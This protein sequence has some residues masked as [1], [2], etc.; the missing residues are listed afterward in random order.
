MAASRPLIKP[1]VRFSRIRL[2]RVGTP[3]IAAPVTRQRK[4]RGAESLRAEAPLTPDHGINELA[5]A[6]PRNRAAAFSWA[7][8]IFCPGSFPCQSVYHPWLTEF[9]IIFFLLGICGLI[10][11]EVDSF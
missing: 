9:E 8:A 5:A 4:V 6:I 10:P 7:K 1:D 2:I 11:V 3:F